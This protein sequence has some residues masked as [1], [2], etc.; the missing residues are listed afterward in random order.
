MEVFRKMNILGYENF[1]DIFQGHQKQVFLGGPFLFIFG[2]F[3]K[4]K[5]KNWNILGVAK[6]SNAVLGMS[7]I[8]DMY[9]DKQMM[10]SPSI[11]GSKR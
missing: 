11:I 6:I 7:V 4:V 8:S 3:L 5:V 1:V 9:G 2:S 10:L